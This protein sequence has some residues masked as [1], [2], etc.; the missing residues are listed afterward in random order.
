MGSLADTTPDEAVKRLRER[1]RVEV[2][3]ITEPRHGAEGRAALRAGASGQIGRDAAP[4]TIVAALHA[5]ASG[6]AT[7]DMSV[8][9]TLLRSR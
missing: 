5:A 3:V 9:E 7:M 4:A 6:L 1:A 8:L 2:I